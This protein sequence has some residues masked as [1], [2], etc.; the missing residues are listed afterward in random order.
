[1]EALFYNKK[2]IT[3]NTDIR[4]YDF[5]NPKNIFI[6]G[7][8]SLEGIKEFVESPITEVPEQIRQRYDINTWIE[9]YLP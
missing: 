3:N 7:E 9:H 4:R 2:L 8:D 5:Y 6:F 1:M